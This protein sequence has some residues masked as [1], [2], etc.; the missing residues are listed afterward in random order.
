LSRNFIENRDR[1]NI[2][3]ITLGST[4]QDTINLVV[5]GLN[6]NRNRGEPR[7]WTKEGLEVKKY[8]FDTEVLQNN[9]RKSFWIT[10]GIDEKYRV[11]N[12]AFYYLITDDHEHSKI[13]FI[14]KSLKNLEKNFNQKY[15]PY[16]VIIFHA[17]S[18]EDQETISKVSNAVIHWVDVRDLFPKDKFPDLPVFSEMKYSESLKLG[19]DCAHGRYKWN[20]GYLNMIRFRSVLLWREPILQFFDYIIQIDSD[21]DIIE[22]NKD[23]FNEIESLNRVFGYYSCVSD[24][25]CTKGLY[26]KTNEYVNSRGIKWKH[27]EKIQDPVA[28]YGN[29]LIFKTNWFLE[30]QPLLDYFDYIDNL[31]GIYFY[32]WAEQVM[33]PI[34]LAMHLEFEKVYWI[35]DSKLKLHHY[36]VQYPQPQRNCPDMPK[37]YI[38]PNCCI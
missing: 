17:I 26:D 15:G 23:L 27:R 25:S 22:A 24:P 20:M 12:G 2:V 28:Y 35:G 36:G 32:R 33:L 4:F 21:V 8:N 9:S 7:L 14:T 30:N 34:I 29:F 37:G 31:G 6:L 10:L 13:G 38:A 18:Q 16:P 3:R 1:T 5:S 19:Q 11:V